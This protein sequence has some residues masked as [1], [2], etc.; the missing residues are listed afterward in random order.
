MATHDEFVDYTLELMACLGAVRARKMFGGYGIYLDDLMF[1]IVADD[2]VYLKADDL[3]R[4]SFVQ[5][6]LEP[7]RLESKN[8]VM[9]YFT[10]PEEAMDDAN[11]MCEWA[12][13]GLDAA[14][15]AA[16]AKRPRKKRKKG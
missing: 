16:K 6:G 5:A 7:F 1:G 14:Q 8:A 11:L 10:V 2:V 3:S 9:S 4:E 13:R 12:Q 15:R